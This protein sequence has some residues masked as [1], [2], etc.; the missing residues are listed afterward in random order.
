[1]YYF[2]SKIKEINIIKLLSKLSFFVFFIHVLVLEI[3]WFAIFKNIFINFGGLIA[4]NLIFDCFY[5]ISVLFVSYFIAFL[6]H[7]IPKLSKLTG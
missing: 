5:F 2:F 1:M 4:G 6:I 7:K 3:L